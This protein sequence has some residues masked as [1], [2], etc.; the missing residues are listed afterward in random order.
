MQ[1]D[2]P[3]VGGMKYVILLLGLLAIAAIKYGYTHNPNWYK[4]LYITLPLLF[5]FVVLSKKKKLANS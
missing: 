3:S 5:I 2:H 4:L 1:H